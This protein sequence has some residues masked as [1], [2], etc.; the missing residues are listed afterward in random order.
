MGRVVSPG[1]VHVVRYEK[2]PI[3]G[4]SDGVFY[5]NF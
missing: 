4:K 5:V 2:I 1:V 3:G